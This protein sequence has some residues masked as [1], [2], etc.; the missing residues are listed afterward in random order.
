MNTE[1]ILLL[2]EVKACFYAIACS[3]PG[4]DQREMALHGFRTVEEVIRK[5]QQPNGDAP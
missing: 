1:C 3:V 2:D 4:I 5:A